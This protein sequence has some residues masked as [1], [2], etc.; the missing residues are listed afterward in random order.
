MPVYVV[1]TSYLCCSAK[2]GAEQKGL[3]S[4][5]LS[6]LQARRPQPQ[7]P[8][9]GDGQL[10]KQP[11]VF[12]MSISLSTIKFNLLKAAYKTEGE[13]GWENAGVAPL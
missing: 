11:H 3:Q 4:R 12:I 7:E 5:A 13:N 10:L 6:G 2:A 1:A 8:K 9:D